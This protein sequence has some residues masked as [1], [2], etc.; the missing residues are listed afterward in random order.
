MASLINMTMTEAHPVS[1]LGEAL[2][3]GVP[4]EVADRAATNLIALASIAKPDLTQPGLMP[5][6]VH[7]F[8]RGL[9]G[10]WVCMDPHCKK[11]PAV[12]RGGPSGNLFGQPRDVCEC[13]ARVVELYTCRNCGTAYGRA[14]TDQVE[15]PDFLWSEP[16]G[17]L[18]TVT[19]NYDELAPIDL[20][21]EEPVF[22]DQVEPAEYD[23]VT[24]RLNPRQL[25]QR[26]RQVY[27]RANRDSPLEKSRR[28][29]DGYPGEFKP[30]AVCGQRA[31]FGRSSVQDHQ[32]KGDQP[33]QALISKQIQVQPPG[34]V[35]ATKLAPLRGRKVLIFSDSRQTAARL[36]PNLQTYSTQDALRPLIISGYARLADSP[37]I[38][39]YCL[40]RIYT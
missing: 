40:S 23:L 15:A 21:L 28:P 38:A 30:C 4:L 5:C 6:R 12:H 33:F 35:R 37:V 1:A 32:T 39:V 18:R 20:L 26:N 8:Y 7:S 19:G 27:L 3:E 11:L 10:L 36:A 34:P 22:R 13:G 9:A 31:A 17:A 14:Y 25:G 16:G 2:F 29:S 24:G